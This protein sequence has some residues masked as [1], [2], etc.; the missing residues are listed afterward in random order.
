MTSQTKVPVY[1]LDWK[2]RHES[3][4][5]YIEMMEYRL[6]LATALAEERA[7]T[8]ESLNQ[9]L[10][11]LINQQKIEFSTTPQQKNGFMKKCFFSFLSKGANN[12]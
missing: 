12:D 4:G 1:K 10:A 3:I 8:I 11:S 2:K 7:K 6:E 5:R 9:T